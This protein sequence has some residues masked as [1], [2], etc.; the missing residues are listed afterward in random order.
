MATYLTRTGNQC[1]AEIKRYDLPTGVIDIVFR[2]IHTGHANEMCYLRLPKSVE[3][4]IVREYK[5]V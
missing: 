2:S 3:T 5:F 4:A 1:S